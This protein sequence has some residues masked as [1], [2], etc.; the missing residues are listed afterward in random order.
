[1]GQAVALGAQH[2]GQ[3]GLSGKGIVVD[4]HRT[5]AQGHGSGLEAQ[6]VQLCHA[7]FRPV[8]GGGADLRPGHLE[9][10][11]HA[12]AHRPAAQ[13]VAAGGR[14]EHRIHVQCGSTAEDGTHV[15]GIHDALQHSHPAGIP[16]YLLYCAGRGAAEGTQ[17]AAGQFVAGQAG[18]HL[19]VG[20]VYRGVPA[21]GQDVL[22]RAGDLFA[23]HEQGQRLVAGIQRPRDHLGAL[24]N[25]NALF[26]LQS[27]AQLGLGQA[28][29]DVQ[30]WR[31]KISDLNDVGHG[32]RLLCVFFLF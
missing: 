8:G 12:H 11:T 20:R 7:V 27:I 13:R 4:A 3:F 18:Q 5:V 28:G 10:R 19:A 22:G 31:G 16:A 30:L 9:H 15:G 32:K 17:H 23:F 1:M 21:A 25:K 29:V 6:S 2:N 14:D 26:R 24:G